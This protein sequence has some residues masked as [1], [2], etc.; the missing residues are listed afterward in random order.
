MLPK[1]GP[2]FVVLI[3]FGRILGDFILL[4]L[5]LEIVF[6]V[7]IVVFVVEIPDQVVV[8]GL[9]LIFQFLLRFEI[10]VWIRNARMTADFYRDLLFGHLVSDLRL[11]LA[12]HPI[13]N[14]PGSQARY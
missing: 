8:F 6:E 7:I 1:F 4:I 11:N 3:L 14:P 2:D 13:T 12:R 10:V 9:V 5:I